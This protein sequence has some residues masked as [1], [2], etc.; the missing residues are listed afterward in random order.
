LNK[1]A[2]HQTGYNLQSAQ[3]ASHRTERRLS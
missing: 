1:F 3:A 2:K